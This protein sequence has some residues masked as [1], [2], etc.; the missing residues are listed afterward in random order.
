MIFYFEMKVA[1]KMRWP[2]CE[3]NIFD[4]HQSRSVAG[5]NRDARGSHYVWRKGMMMGE[6]DSSRS[7]LGQSSE[8]LPPSLRENF[9]ILRW[10]H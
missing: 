3:H 2:R 9:A 10:P 7:L 5:R 6:S 1:G 4:W 8:R